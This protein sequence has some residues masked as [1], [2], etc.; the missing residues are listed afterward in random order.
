MT[1]QDFLRV[2]SE[3]EQEKDFLNSVSQEIWKNPE[4]SYEER[5]AHE[6]LTRALTK[7]G[8]QVQKH[9][10]LSTAFRAD[11]SSEEGAGPTVAI[12]LEY[13][14]LPELGHACGHNLIAEAGLAAAM[15]VKRAME[16]DC[17]LHGKLVVLGTPAEEGGGGK[18]KMLNEGAFH[19]IH[20]A[21]MVHPSL[22]NHVSPVLLCYVQ[23]VIEFKGK[24]AHAGATPWEGRNALDAAVCCYQSIGL[25]RQQIKPTWRIQTIITKGGTVANVIPSLTTM[26]VH[27]RTPT[28]PER[29]DLQVKIEA[30]FTSSAIATGCE[31][32]FQCIETGSYDNMVT[33]KTLAN[34]YKKHAER[35]GS[36]VF[37]LSSGMKHIDSTL[38]SYRIFISYHMIQKSLIL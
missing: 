23:Y 8:F 34:V 19:G 35:L 32:Q 14:A 16:A 31:V 9:Y 13:D 3:I 18:I 1:E 24:E 20:A 29:K 2:C 4:L 21:M 10:M 22:Y 28:R 33:N 38:K 12:I 11:V 30:C 5:H 27:L 6:V 17:S 26:E 36:Y 7:Y 25:L 15:A 37:G